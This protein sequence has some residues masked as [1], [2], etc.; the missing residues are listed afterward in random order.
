MKLFTHKS[1]DKHVQ[2]CV[3]DKCKV[4]NVN[5]K[6]GPSRSDVPH[7]SFLAKFRV[8]EVEEF[9]DIKDQSGQVAN[10]EEK[11]DE[12]ENLGS[13]VFS[14]SP[15]DVDRFDSENACSISGFEGSF[16]TKKRKQNQLDTYD[17]GSIRN[18]FRKVCLKFLLRLGNF[19][20]LF[21]P[22]SFTSMMS[23]FSITSLLLMMAI[24][25]FADCSSDFSEGSLLLDF[26]GIP[27]S[28][29]FEEGSSMESIASGSCC[30]GSSVLLKV[31]I[32]KVAFEL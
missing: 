13:S 4:T 15:F 19:L 5:H 1:I 10:D 14:L 11:S 31:D 21:S 3:Q 25:F 24:A 16:A 2:R 8:F 12:N 20:V 23:T 30:F 7:S 29:D 9:V 18:L 22:F 17:P 27:S 32:L 6:I 28:L 26:S